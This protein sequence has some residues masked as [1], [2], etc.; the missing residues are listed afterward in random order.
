[1]EEEEKK[2][3]GGFK[4]FLGYFLVFVLGITIG[5]YATIQKAKKKNDNSA[6]SNYIANNYPQTGSRGVYNSDISNVDFACSN[7]RKSVTIRFVP[8]NDINNLRVLVELY[9][10]SEYLLD[11]QVIT[12]GGVIHG[13]QYTVTATLPNNQ[14]TAG[15]YIKSYTFHVY[16][17]TV[18]Y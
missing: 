1:M 9:D 17:G 7:D 14:I 18:D 4:K 2:K 3:S 16:S 5:C 6:F 15:K 8:K 11:S 13:Q 12:V 10:S